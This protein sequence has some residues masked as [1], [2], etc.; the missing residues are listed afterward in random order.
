MSSGRPQEEAPEGFV[1]VREA[2][3][4]LG[5]S[6]QMVRNYYRSGRLEG[7]E[8]LNEKQE[9]RYHIS[10]ESLQEFAREAGVATSGDVR[11]SAQEVERLSRDLASRIIEEIVSNRETVSGRLDDLIENQRALAK[12]MNEANRDA[13]EAAQTEKRYQ[14]DVIR[15]MD[16]FASMVEEQQRL[17][18]E[19]QERETNYL[20]WK[21]G[22]I[23]IVI[24]LVVGLALLFAIYLELGPELQRVI[25]P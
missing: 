4:I 23:L 5:R 11:E 18:R 17:T 25:A 16:R 12:E 21:I 8:F 2:A 19:Q 9:Q 7:Q 10:I 15:R 3:E 6:P 24:L 20:P 22:V 13:R 1:T 14:E